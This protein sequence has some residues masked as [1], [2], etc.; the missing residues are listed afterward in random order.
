MNARDRFTTIFLIAFGVA[1]IAAGVFVWFA[2]SGF[3]DAKA[4]FDQSATEL[5][6][7]QHLAPFPN[8][9]NLRKS[10][11]QAEQYAA[12]LNKSKEELKKHVLP[13]APMA[14]NEFQVRLRQAMASVADHARQNRV[15]LPDNFYLG[16]EEYAAALPDTAATP[17]LGQQL[18]QVEL[19]MN[20]LIDARVDAVT[21]LRRVSAAELHTA[22][23]SL[24]ATP[25]PAAKSAPSS[26]PGLL[27]RSV[28]DASFVST[29]SATRRALNQITTA[30]QQFYIIRTL[31]VVNEKDKGPARDG[32]AVTG[33]IPS[34]TAGAGA[35]NPALTFIV[36]NEHVQTSA[37]IE[38]VRFTF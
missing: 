33:V 9:V 22:A 18:A 25:S 27:E 1:V 26:T 2:K 11:E 10:K 4:Q 32:A 13:V 30:N 7:L 38:I 36:G 21:A 35:A 5:N 31:H 16:F 15:K 14:P 34:T 3:D 24:A 8:E 28:V 17:L 20:M 23:T 29:P 6:R 37:R 19:L 12:E